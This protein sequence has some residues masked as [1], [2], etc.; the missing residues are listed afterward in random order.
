MTVAQAREVLTVEAEG[1]LAVRERLGPE[2]EQAV[3]L[4][5]ECPSRTGDYRYRQ[6]GP[7]GTENRRYPEFHRDALFFSPPGGGHA[8]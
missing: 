6:V 5:M 4:I 3:G 7:G 8:W 1:I 2:F